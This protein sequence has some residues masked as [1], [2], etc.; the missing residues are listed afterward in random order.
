MEEDTSSSIAWLSLDERDNDPAQFLNYG[1]G[2]PI[3]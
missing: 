1:D 2:S 3:L